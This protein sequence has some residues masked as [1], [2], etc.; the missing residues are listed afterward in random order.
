MLKLGGSERSERRVQ[1]SVRNED[2]RGSC[3]YPTEE[4]QCNAN[5]RLSAGRAAGTLCLSS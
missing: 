1:C 2:T 3:R 5:I 4:F